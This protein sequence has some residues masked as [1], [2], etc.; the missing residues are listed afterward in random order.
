MRI[1]D[2]DFEMKRAR[3]VE[4]RFVHCNEIQRLTAEGWDRHYV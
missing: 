4:V 1:L 3:P 2:D